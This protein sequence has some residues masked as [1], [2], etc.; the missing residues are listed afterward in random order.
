M[1]RALEIAENL[2]EVRDRIA[3]ACARV[4]RDKASVQLIAVSKQKP[5]DDVRAAL[6][7]GQRAF[8][9]NYAQELEEKAA[10][11]GTALPEWH[12][13]G[14]L[15]TNKVKLVVGRAVLVHAVDRPS[16]VRELAKRAAALGRV[17][18][19]LLEV[20]VGAEEQKG[21]C[22]V[23]ALPGLVRAVA[24]EPAL[25]CDGLMCI[26]PAEGDPRRH[27]Q[28]LRALRDRLRDAGALGARA[29]LSMG[30]SGDYEAAIEEGATMVR[31]GS[32]I[33]GARQKRA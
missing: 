18:R 4:G 15:Q 10:A 12:F 1:T 16:L 14:A 5:I 2:A 25:A 31:V 3:R 7:A 9:E 11:L 28:A 29:E 26:P 17:Q 20:N 33:F 22:A 21:G 24:A 6:A 23:E 13:L 8:G 30:M 32:A 19:V 27:F